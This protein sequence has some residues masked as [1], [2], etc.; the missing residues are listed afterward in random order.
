MFARFETRVIQQQRIVLSL[1]RHHTAARMTLAALAALAALA[2]LAT[3][4]TLSAAVGIT[5][6]VAAVAVRAAAAVLRRKHAC[7]RRVVILSRR[8]RQRNKGRRRR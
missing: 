2:T 4:V 8:G 7:E 5:A 1:G 6:A 3:L